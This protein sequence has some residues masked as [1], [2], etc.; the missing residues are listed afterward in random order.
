MLYRAVRREEDGG[1]ESLADL[2]EQRAFRCRLVPERALASV[3]EAEGFLRDRGLLT[4]TADCAL[5]SLYE[6]CHEDPY[7]A[8]GAGFASWPATKWPWFGALAERGYLP[9]AVHRGKNLLVSAEVAALLDP[10]CR[11]EIARMRAADRGWARLLDHLAA[12]G[13]SSI[14]DLRTELGLKRPE[15]KALRSPLERCGAIVSRSPVVAAG[16]GHRHSSELARWDQAYPGAGGTDA[17]P[18][19]AFGDLLVAGV[20]AAVVA[21]E[22]DLPRWFSWQW[23]LTGPLIDDLVREGRL[24]RVA[25]QVVATRKSSP[26][27]MRSPSG[28]PAK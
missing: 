23:Y 18:R 3:E 25:G 16:E 15:L 11:A 28:R 26:V 24:R 17:D 21:P 2:L 13:P 22:A 7:Q 6:A 14:D 19:R 27:D 4:R 9:T 12:A 1:V 10:V 8:G 20:R 5:P